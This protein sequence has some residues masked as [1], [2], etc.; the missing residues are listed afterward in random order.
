MPLPPSLWC[1]L[2]SPA[3]SCHLCGSR[4]FPLPTSLPPRPC[5]CCPSSG[6]REHTA[7]HYKTTPLARPTKP[8]PDASP[9]IPRQ[10]FLHSR[11]FL[12]ERPTAPPPLPTRAFPKRLQPATAALQAC[13]AAGPQLHTHYQVLLSVPQAA[14][15]SGQTPETA[16]RLCRLPTKGGRHF[17]RLLLSKHF[18]SGVHALRWAPPGLLCSTSPCAF[19]VPSHTIASSLFHAS[20]SPLRGADFGALLTSLATCLILTSA[21][22]HTLLPEQAPHPTALVPRC[23]LAFSTS[24]CWT[25]RPPGQAGPALPWAP[26]PTHGAWA[27]LAFAPGGHVGTISPRQP[28]CTKR[29]PCS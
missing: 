1:Q 13:D 16:A 24:S 17:A 27:F 8:H 25:A 3:R 26:L 21:H 4:H 18:P 29:G 20:A 11:C 7:S 28:S 14:A 12:T 19:A 22:G 6:P 2:R 15:I 10:S 23:W 9:S 5:R